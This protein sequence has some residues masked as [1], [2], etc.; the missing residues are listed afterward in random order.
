MRTGGDDFLTKPVEPAQ[1][2]SVVSIRTER[3][4]SLSA[5]IARDSLTGL[6]NK[7]HTYEAL[8]AEAARALRHDTELSF[9]LIDIDHFRAI[10]ETHGYPSGDRV[11]KG[12][13]RLFQER[14][15]RSDQIGRTGGGEFAVIIPHG[16]NA[17]TATL[18]NDVRERFSRLRYQTEAGA[19]HA[20]FSGGIATLPAFGEPVAL[21]RA[22]QRALREAKRRGRNRVELAAD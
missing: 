18:L 22:A 5:L 6:A 8:E 2:V 7:G 21:D 9:A 12:L 3:W 14:L 1:L 13:A 20:T 16:D 4:R 15:R 17:A 11:I 10:N 19:F